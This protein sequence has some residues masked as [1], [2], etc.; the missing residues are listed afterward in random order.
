M[1]T[2]N[3][4]SKKT[5][6]KRASPSQ[7]TLSCALDTIGHRLGEIN[8]RLK[9]QEDPSQCNNVHLLELETMLIVQYN[10]LPQLLLMSFRSYTCLTHV[11]I[12]SITSEN[13]HEVC[14][15]VYVDVRSSNAK[16]SFKAL[17]LNY[18]E[19]SESSLSV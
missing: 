7:L 5:N 16:Q 6:K 12:S 1:K 3:I 18:L 11:L 19:M 9:L 2:V 4:N 8:Q 15:S 13:Q 14:M 17:G 10:L